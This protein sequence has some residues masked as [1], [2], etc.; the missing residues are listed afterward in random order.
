MATASDEAFAYSLVENYLESWSKIDLD[1][2]KIES[3]FDAASNRKKKGR[4]L[5]ANTPRVP[6]EQE[7]MQDG[8][9]RD[10]LDLMNYLKK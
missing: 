4:L 6:M 8:W 5:G 10:C 3:T 2:Y 1:Q 7:D 9:Q